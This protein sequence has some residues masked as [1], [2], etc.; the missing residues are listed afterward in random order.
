MDYFDRLSERLCNSIWLLKF[1][2]SLAELDIDIPKQLV[3]CKMRDI[4]KGM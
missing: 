1:Y 3:G 4:Q 2:G